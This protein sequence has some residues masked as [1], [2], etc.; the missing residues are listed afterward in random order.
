[1]GG[2]IGRGLPRRVTTDAIIDAAMA[3]LVAVVAGTGIASMTIDS[4]SNSEG[5]STGI[6]DFHNQ[7][8]FMLF[9]LVVTH[10]ARHRNRRRGRSKRSREVSQRS[11][12][13]L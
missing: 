7:A 1:V 10:V 3:V 5:D 6:G 9:A 11:A 8:A 4:S 2:R 12:V 13:R